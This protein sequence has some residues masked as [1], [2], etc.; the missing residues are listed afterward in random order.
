MKITDEYVIV[1]NPYDTAKK[2]RI[3]RADFEKMTN[4]FNVAKI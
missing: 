4:H 2:E 1:A 3:P